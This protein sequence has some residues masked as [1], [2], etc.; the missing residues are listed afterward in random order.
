MACSF[1]M[2]GDH[3]NVRKPDVALEVAEHD[4]DLFGRGDW[5]Q[6]AWVKTKLQRAYNCDDAA[7]AKRQLKGFRR[8]KGHKEMPKLTTLSSTSRT[9]QICRW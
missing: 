2:V 1:L 6:R 3:L 8:L 7:V 5:R 4:N 9:G